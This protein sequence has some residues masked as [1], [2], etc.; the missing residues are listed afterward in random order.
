MLDQPADKRSGI[1]KEMFLKGRQKQ[2]EGVIVLIANIFALR[3]CWVKVHDDDSLMI[4]NIL[5]DIANLLSSTEYK[6]FDEKYK[7]SKN[8]MAHI[9]VVYIFNIFA[10]FVKAAKIP[11]VIREFKCTNEI[12]LKHFKM[13][14]IMKGNLMDQ[15]NL[16]IVTCSRN[17]IFHSAPLTLKSFCP[18][19][20]R[21]GVKKDNAVNKKRTLDKV[22]SS[23]IHNNNNK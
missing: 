2:L 15:L 19:L 13:A 23:Q 4:L 6:I 11:K 22:N 20:V 17:I 3:R 14:S 9:L 21:E 10:V 8:Y 1:R 18:D 7:G 12:K 5:M 16:C